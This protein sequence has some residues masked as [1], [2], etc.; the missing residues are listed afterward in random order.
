MSC[1]ALETQKQKKII[2]ININLLMIGYILSDWVLQLGV[3]N[4]KRWKNMEPIKLLLYNFI[5]IMREESKTEIFS[6]IFKWCMYKGLIIYVLLLFLD[7]WWFYVIF[8]VYWDSFLLRISS[9]QANQN[10]FE[11]NSRCRKLKTVV[12]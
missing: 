2:Q 7:N 5:V 6:T 12:R 10:F 1:T 4:K 11:S 3:L 9:Y 8:R